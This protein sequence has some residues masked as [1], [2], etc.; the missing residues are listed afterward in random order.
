MQYFSKILLLF[1]LVFSTEINAQKL[2]RIL[3]KKKSSTQWYGDPVTGSSFVNKANVLTTVS[4]GGGTSNYYGDMT[5]Y[6]VP[7]ATI[8]KMTRWNLSANYTKHFK[9][10]LAARIGLTYARISGDDDNFRNAPVAFLGKY[11]R[12]LHFKNDLKEIQLVGVYD[13]AKYRRGGAET[14]QKLTPYAFA[15]IAL[16]NHNPKALFPRNSSGDVVSSKWE[17]LRDIDTEGL[18]TL[19]GKIYSTVALTLPIGMGFKYKLNNSFDISAEGG[20]RYT[21][22]KS[23]RYLDDVSGKY[24]LSSGPNPGSNE[25]FFYRSNPAFEAYAARTGNLRE[26]SKITL[27]ITNGPGTVARGNGRQDIYFLTTFQLNYYLPSK[28][29]CPSPSIR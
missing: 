15:G 7:I 25:I 11:S 9:Y 1:I 27:P 22:G 6:H 8:L 21:F 12:G 10:N 5:S 4:F 3:G 26:V 19:N 23:G 2:P 20:L 29:K 24:I 13:F 28:I 14:R 18:N 17:K 16:L